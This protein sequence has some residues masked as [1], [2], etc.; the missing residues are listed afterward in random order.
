MLFLTEDFSNTIIR[1]EGFKL[2]WGIINALTLSGIFYIVYY[3]IDPASLLHDS[4][5]FS[6]KNFPLSLVTSLFIHNSLG[7]LFANISAT[8]LFGTIFF[9]YQGVFKGYGYFIGSGVIGHLLEI[10]FVILLNF[11]LQI[12]IERLMIADLSHIEFI[13]RFPSEAGASGGIAGMGVIVVLKFFDRLKKLFRNINDP[14]E[15]TGKWYLTFNTFNTFKSIICFYSLFLVVFYMTLTIIADFSALFSFL[16]F[17]FVSFFPDFISVIIH[18][19]KNILPTRYY[20][21]PFLAHFFSMIG[22]ILL[23][24][25][26]QSQIV[27]KFIHNP[28]SLTLKY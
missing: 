15:P 19:C 20:G 25:F 1:E 18:F 12:N 24:R 2:L 7:H 14:N 8:I 6:I 21:H 10:V 4:L 26:E 3:W 17:Q 23:R 27:R 22:V 5:K 11:L 13:I 16:H 9:Y 28:E